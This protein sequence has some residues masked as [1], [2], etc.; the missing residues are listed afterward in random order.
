MQL[1]RTV[2]NT[3]IA[4]LLLCAGLLSSGPCYADGR[5]V[6]IAIGTSVVRPQENEH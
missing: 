1:T 4:T 3:G 6:D 2:S 5:V